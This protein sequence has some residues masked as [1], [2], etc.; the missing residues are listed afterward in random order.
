MI[1]LIW[2]GKIPKDKAATYLASLRAT[3]LKDYANT[4]GNLGA[5]C[6]HR[7]LGPHAEFLRITLWES[8]AAIKL[9]AGEDH[10]KARYYPADDAFL[11]EKEP[12][13]EHYE[14]SDAVGLRGVN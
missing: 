5:F 1:M 2:R 9:F 4:P 13:V 10:E 12:F 3:G 6:V 7:E 8:V 11:N 14:V